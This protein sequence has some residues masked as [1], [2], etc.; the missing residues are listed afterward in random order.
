MTVVYVPTILRS[1]AEICKTFGVGNRRVIEW[2]VAGAPIA[3][4]GEG[5]KMRYSAELIR[6]QLWREEQ[7]PRPQD[8][9]SGD[10]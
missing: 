7:T 1:M 4:E 2:V 5:A 6:L 9:V 10:D 3:V 8:D